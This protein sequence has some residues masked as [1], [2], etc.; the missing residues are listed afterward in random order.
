MSCFLCVSRFYRVAFPEILHLKLLIS[1]ANHHYFLTG[2]MHNTVASFQHWSSYRIREIFHWINLSPSPA[3]FLLQKNFMEKIFGNKPCISS[4]RCLM[5]GKK[6]YDNLK[7]FTNESTWVAKLVKVFSW[8]KFYI[9]LLVKY[10]LEEVS[11]WFRRPRNSILYN[12]DE[13]RVLWK[14]WRIF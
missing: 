1:F 11:M 8:R 6:S 12:S 4:M 3:T 13:A 9:I 7:I 10:C 14:P 2:S 5:P